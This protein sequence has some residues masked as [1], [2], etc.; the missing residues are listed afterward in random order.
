VRF[1]DLD[2]SFSP[3]WFLSLPILFVIRALLERL[4]GF[5]AMVPFVGLSSSRPNVQHLF[6]SAFGWQKRRRKG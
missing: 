4:D 5:G 2:I 6:L 3:L 1:F